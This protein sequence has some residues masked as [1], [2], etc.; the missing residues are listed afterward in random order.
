MPSNSRARRA[1]ELQVRRWASSRRRTRCRAEEAVDH[2]LGRSAPSTLSYRASS[3]RARARHVVVLVRR[4]PCRRKKKHWLI[5]TQDERAE[6]AQP[7]TRRPVLG[8]GQGVDAY[9]KSKLLRLVRYCD[10]VEQAA[11]S[12]SLVTLKVID[13]SSARIRTAV[14]SEG[15]QPQRRRRR[16]PAS[17]PRTTPRR[18]LRRSR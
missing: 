4:G 12:S 10:E 17:V 18:Y 1:I 15:T 6:P 11:A 3:P 9:S 2:D 16:R 8:D 14:A 13:L 5:F 7:Q